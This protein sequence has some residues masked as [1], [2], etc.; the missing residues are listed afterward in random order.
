[1]ALIKEVLKLVRDGGLLSKGDIADKMGIQESTLDTVFSLLSS[2][3]YL[4]KFDGA[5][6]VPRA[7]IGCSMSKGCL[8]NASAGGVYVITDKGKNYLEEN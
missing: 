6:E 7:C 4:R 8:E 3:G 1:L 5:T 2:K